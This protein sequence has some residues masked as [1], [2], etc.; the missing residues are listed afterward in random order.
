MLY[1]PTLKKNLLSISALEEQGYVVL[2]GQV[3]IHSK[4]TSIDIVVSIDVKESKMCRL[5]SKPIGGSKWILDQ[6]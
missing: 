1:I 6:C 4:G 2:F 3:L 5:Q